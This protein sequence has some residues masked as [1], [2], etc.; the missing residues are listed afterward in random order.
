[1]YSGNI[2]ADMMDRQREEQEKYCVNCEELWRSCKCGEPEANQ[3]TDQSTHGGAITEKPRLRART[4][5]GH[6]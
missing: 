1:M 4:L 2:I 6:P 3:E 5:R